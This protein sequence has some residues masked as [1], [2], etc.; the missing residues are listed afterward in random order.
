MMSYKVKSILKNSLLVEYRSDNGSLKEL[1]ISVEKDWNKFRIEEEIARQKLFEDQKDIDLNLSQYFD[2]GE[3]LEFI[4][5]NLNEEL[6]KEELK[7]YE[8]QQLEL[9]E[10]EDQELL[11]QIIDYRNKAVPY[12]EVRYYEYPNLVEQLDAL[13][14][15][16]QGVME[17]IQKID[18]QITNVKQKYPKDSPTNLTYG[19]L[20]SMFSDKRPTDY[21]DFLKSR[22]IKADFID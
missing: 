11:T 12:D 15:M 19:D 1:Y 10:K 5:I 8:Q 21:I 9:K 13:Y 4:N 7:K 22:D 3:E 18:E 20:D 6:L 16:R 2:K 17:P 14:W